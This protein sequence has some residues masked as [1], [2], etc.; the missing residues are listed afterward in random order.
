MT[1]DCLGSESQMERIL[2]TGGAGF[3]ASH[4]VDKLVEDYEI[5][6]VDD[7]SSGFLENLSNHKKHSNLH[8]IK[9]SI[10]DHHTLLSALKGVT[11]V[12][13]FAAQADVK[14]SFEKPLHD[15]EVNVMGSLRLLEAMRQSDVQRLVF[16]SSGGTVYGDAAEIPTSEQAPFRPISNYGAAKA[17]IEMYLSSYSELYGMEIASLRYGNIIGPRLRRGVIFDFYNK[18]RGNKSRLEVLGTGNQEKTYLYVTDAIAA[19]LKVAKSYGKGFMPINISSQETLKVSRIAEIV[20]HE[21]G[22]EDTEIVYTGSQRGWPGDVKVTNMDVSL[23]Q[24]L[25]WS[26][27]VPAGEAVRLSVAWLVNEYGPAK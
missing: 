5:V 11:S 7:L 27:Q 24:S 12:Y 21:L 23:L 15:F 17:S 20:I 1:S 16:A 6:I 13:H 22:L 26:P 18:L 2:I 8:F 4:L 10:L 14:L 3:I 19:T 9:R 25:G